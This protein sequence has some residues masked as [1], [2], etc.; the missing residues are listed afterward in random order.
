MVRCPQYANDAGTVRIAASTR[1]T[2]TATDR[3]RS[4]RAAGGD[5]DAVP[6]IRRSSHVPHGDA[7]T[8]R[9]QP[10]ACGWLVPAVLGRP[11]VDRSAPVREGPSS[12]AD[13]PTGWAR[14]EERAERG[15]PGRPRGRP[16]ESALRPL[17]RRGA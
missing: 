9:V 2:T 3:P 10:R 14:G 16:G 1:Q 15:V 11:S 4:L 7:Q 13:D 8:M 5:T 12:G 17:G 6:A